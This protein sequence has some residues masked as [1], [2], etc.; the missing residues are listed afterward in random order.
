MRKH[1]IIT[2]SLAII[3][4]LVSLAYL[5]GLRG[6]FVLDDAENISRDPSIALNN[7]NWKG[8]RKVLHADAHGPLKRP[9]ASLTFALN[10]YWAGGFEATSYFKITNLIIHAINTVLVYGVL[11]LLLSAPRLRETLT[12]SE[13]QVVATLGT[14]LWAIHPIQLT[15]VLYVVQRMNSLS[16]L[17]M[18]TGLILFLLGRQRLPASPTK[19]LWLMSGGTFG[20]IALGLTAK[21]TAALIPLYLGVV[22]YTIFTREGLSQR[23][24]RHLY[25]FYAMSFA[26]PVAVFVTYVITH[27]NFFADAYSTRQF[28]AYERLLTET[29]VLWYYVGLILVPS[30][31]RLSLFHDDIPPSHGLLDPLTTCVATTGIM[32]VLAFALFKAKRFPVAAFAILWFL[33]GHSMEST[34]IDLE[35]VYE[36]RN[37]LPSLGPFFGFAYGLILLTKMGSTTRLPWYGIAAA[38]VGMLGIGTWVR[39]DSWKDIHSFAVTEAEHHPDSERAND[40]AARVS[41]IEEQDLGESMK[42]TLRGAKTTPGEV[43][44]LI[45]LQILLVLLPPE[46]SLMAAS[47]PVPAELT[48]T[49]TIT[50]L[51]R[52]KPVSVH[53][54]VSFENLRRC[55]V[56]PPHPCD[57]L[58]DKAT[59]WLKVAADESHTSHDYRGILAANVAQLS[60]Y[61]GDYK[62][63]YEYMNRASAAFPHLISYKLGLA[64][65]MLKLGCQE[66]VK[67]LLEQI[68]RMAQQN[69]GLNQTNQTSLNKLEEMYSALLKQ[70][71]GVPRT[72]EQ[73]CYK[74]DK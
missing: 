4:L 55:I 10:Y 40:F 28:T 65:Y 26:L 35:L 33:V 38:L 25:T 69:N 67:P 21:E 9:L 71:S 46:H 52:E 39:A 70:G 56:M 49:D 58:R 13:Q 23:T 1:L 5:P 8:I 24:R 60:A 50:R 61:A 18:L 51:L 34:I 74:M 66:R 17:F 37:Y 53:G 3:L 14:A 73:L 68:E 72:T 42:Y 29:R 62:Q 2:G 19:A 30:T 11:I 6:P 31:Q 27:P 59:Q 41:L 20:G 54:V 63:A 43:G 12:Q 47:M 16:T 64:E 22:E 45:D 36:H 44:F 57:S 32:A 15:N 7:L 48:A